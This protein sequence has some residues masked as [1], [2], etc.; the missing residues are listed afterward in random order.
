MARSSGS[1][2]PEVLA[3]VVVLVALGLGAAG[4][5]IAVA[6]G[7]GSAPEA[8][9]GAAPSPLPR[10]SVTESSV[11]SLSPAREVLRE[12]DARREAAWADADDEALAA[13]YVPGAVAG[14]RDVTLLRR[15]SARGVHVTRLEPQVLDLRVLRSTARRLV[16]RVTDRLGVLEARVEGDVVTLPRDGPSTRRI[17]LRRVRPAAP[18]RVASVSGR[19]PW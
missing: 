7:S 5:G 15:W 16:V 12:W 6:W 11:P 3:A 14:T 8:T 1:S 19:G 4:V 17:E 18:W 9:I 13:L 2:S 10:S